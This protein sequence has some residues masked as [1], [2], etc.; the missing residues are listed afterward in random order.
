MWQIVSKPAK[1]GSSISGSICL[2]I[3]SSPAY[4]QHSVTLYLVHHYEILLSKFMTQMQ[5]PFVC[6]VPI[7]EQNM[8]MAQGPAK[9][10]TGIDALEAPDNNKYKERVPAHQFGSSA[11]SQRAGLRTTFRVVRAHEQAGEGACPRM[12]ALDMAQQPAHHPLPPV[13]ADAS[14]ASASYCT[15]HG[16]T[17]ASALSLCYRRMAPRRANGIVGWL[18]SLLGKD[19][20]QAGRL[21]SDCKYVN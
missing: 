11:L 9:P 13:I 1:K 19:V 10:W 18:R 3:S 14:S 12:D 21:V 17:Y 16:S 8:L 15:S 5:T 7:C 4:A 2:S 20:Q 6:L